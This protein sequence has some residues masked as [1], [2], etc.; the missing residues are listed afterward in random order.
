MR[1]VLSSVTKNKLGDSRNDTATRL[2]NSCKLIKQKQKKSLL[3]CSQYTLGSFISCVFVVSALPALTCL[4]MQSTLNALFFCDPWSNCSFCV[5]NK[6][7]PRSLTSHHCNMHLEPPCVIEKANSTFHH[8][9]GNK[10]K[11]VKP[12]FKNMGQWGETVLLVTTTAW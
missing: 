6:I 3:S 7:P 11:N 10:G 9:S 2:E 5:G 4:L 12:H 1:Q 8:E